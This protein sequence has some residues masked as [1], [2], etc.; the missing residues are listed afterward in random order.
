M[1][2]RR[3]ARLEQ[4]LDRKRQEFT[5]LARRAKRWTWGS[6]TFDLDDFVQDAYSVAIEI[7][8]RHSSTKSDDDLEKM[9]HKG[10]VYHLWGEWRKEVTHLVNTVELTT[11]HINPESDE[12][13]SSY[14]ASVMAEAKAILSE[15]EYE[16][17]EVLIRPEHDV[18]S[19]LC[20]DLF[21]HVE[22][23]PIQRGEFFYLS[24]YFDLPVVE[25]QERFYNL[26]NRM[27]PILEA[28]A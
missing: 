16:M 28:A 25:I 6:A 23:R 7:Y 11:E 22:H 24:L 12:F 4:L 15:F 3:Q 18:T 14:V 17:L 21:K 26:R 27:T 19:Q 10:I 5:G 9:M 20:Y 1:T 2:H 8:R 13:K